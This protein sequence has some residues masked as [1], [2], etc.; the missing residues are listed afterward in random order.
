MLR[1][2]LRVAMYKV[3]TN[4]VEVPFSELHVE[5]ESP[6]SAT[7]TAVEEAVAQLRREAQEVAARQSR[8]PVPK[9]QSAPV[10]QPTAYSSRMIK[11][12]TNLPSS[13]PASLADD[14]W[15]LATA[16]ATPLRDVRKVSSPLSSTQR[17]Q[18]PFEELTSS[19]VK[20]RVAEGLLGLRHAV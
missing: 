15:A 17:L 19:A 8:P 10:L 7:R 3:R 11:Y 5:R 18:P 1:L 12:E 6:Q 9:L 16:V 14:K 2:R 4:Q 13:P 20:G